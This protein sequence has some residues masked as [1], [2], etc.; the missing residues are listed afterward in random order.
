[1]ADH[2][3]NYEYYAY[4][5]KCIRKHDSNAF[6]EL[7]HH[8]YKDIYRYA[9]YILK[10]EHLAQDAMQEIYISVYKNISMLKE[11]RLL[12]SWMRQ[13]TYH[14]CCD[15]LRKPSNVREDSTD[16][17]EDQQMNRLA[18]ETDHFQPVHDRDLSEKMHASLKHLPVPVQQAFLLRFTYELKL[19]EISDFLNCSLSTVKRHLKAAQKHLQKELAIYQKNL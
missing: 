3:L 10:D 12:Y 13:I 4:L 19:E 7:Y 15:F 18:D 5:A 16:F 8:T 11:D 9:W 17:S 14:I 1:M 6:T 2:L